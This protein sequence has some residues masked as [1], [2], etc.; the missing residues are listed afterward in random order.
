M[1]TVDLKTPI[2]NKPKTTLLS[3]RDK[4]YF[5]YRMMQ[6]DYLDQVTKR[7]NEIYTKSHEIK[8]DK[9]TDM[10]NNI[11]KT[12][13][14]EISRVYSFGVSRETDNET[15]KDIINSGLVDKVMKQANKYVNAFNDV[16]L[17]VSWNE[18]TMQPKFIFRLP[19]KTE[20]VIDDYDNIIEVEYLV[21]IQD[22]G[23]EKWAYWSEKEHYYKIKNIAT[24][25]FEKSVING[26]DNGLNPYGVLPFVSMKNG[27]RDGTFWDTFKGDDLVAITLDNAVY[28]TFRNYMIK[29]QSF[30]QIIV[31]GENVGAIKGQVLDP[32]QALTAEGNDV[33]IDVL[34]LQ[35]NL[36]ELRETIESQATNVAIN[37]NI[38]P[39]QFRMTGQVSS[40]FSLQME[41]VNLDEFNQEQQLDYIDYEKELYKLLVTVGNEEGA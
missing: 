25:T 39:S 40:G 11:F 9:Q 18:K 1:S 30:K 38:S 19:H 7:L 24:G 14:E 31:T 28:S 22:D 21:E 41:N 34:D 16:L 29:W 5:R 36:K 17:Q 32:S 8:L 20:V 4:F 13:V 15:M 33:K 26:N 2:L 23:K 3:R 37:Y 27:F 12:V 35:A 10:T 6:D